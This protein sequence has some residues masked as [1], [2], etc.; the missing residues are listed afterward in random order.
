MSAI[1]AEMD[2][3]GVFLEAR[4]GPGFPLGNTAPSDIVDFL[5]HKE[6]SGRTQVHAPSCPRG[7]SRDKK[8]NAACDPIL[9][10]T[11]AA[12]TSIKTAISLL[13]NGF[14]RAGIVGEWSDHTWSGNPVSSYKVS[15]HLGALERELAKSAVVPIQALPIT[16]EE[17]L[18]VL[19]HMR[20]P[21][22][23]NKID[24]LFQQQTIFLYMLLHGT[25]RRPDDVAYTRSV[26][27]Q[28]GPDGKSVIF[29]MFLGKTNTGIRADRLV[30]QEH[31]NPRSCIITQLRRYTDAMRR[32]D[33]DMNQT[34]HLVFFMI[35][36]RSNTIDLSRATDPS[37]MTQRFQ[38]TLNQLGRWRGQTL[39]GFR[40]QAALVAAWGSDD[41]R[42]VM[43]AGGWMSE[44]SAYRYS[45]WALL[46]KNCLDPNASQALMQEWLVKRHEFGVF[47]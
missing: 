6:K 2:R 20:R 40:V 38:A 32:C 43:N 47:V 35:D 10:E 16:E 45:Q 3:L 9:C 33:I 18:M 24:W 21:Y 7:G 19:H 25:G 34:N 12:A 17:Y 4:Y 39:Y 23:D 14:R 44:A 22:N 28:W 15:D 27:F 30:I 11:R 41:I 8:K 5:I 37:T 13:K 26:S 31:A 42:D 1:S 46:A 36:R 29:S